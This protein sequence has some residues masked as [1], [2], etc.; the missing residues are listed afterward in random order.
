MFGD[1]NENAISS[2]YKKPC[3]YVIKLNIYR[4]RL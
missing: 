2:R 4:Y 3:M 1:I